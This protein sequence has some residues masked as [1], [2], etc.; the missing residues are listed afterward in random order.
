[1]FSFVSD[2]DDLPM[3]IKKDLFDELLD[4]DVQKG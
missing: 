3:P 4:K 2:V 1:M